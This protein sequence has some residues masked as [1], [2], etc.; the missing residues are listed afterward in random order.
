[1][2]S[3]EFMDVY[4]AYLF[5]SPSA[6]SAL[7][8][9]QVFNDRYSHNSMTRLLAQPEFSPRKFGKGIPSVIR[10]IEREA[11][12]I[13]IDDTLE[14]TPHTHSAEN[15]LIAWDPSRSVSVKGIQIVTFT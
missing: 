4:S 1:M 7:V 11:G 9:V 8:R 10:R 12:I 6:V 5:S 13:S 3:Q 14:H 2:K 15:D